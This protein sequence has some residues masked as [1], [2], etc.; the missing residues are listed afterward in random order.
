MKSRLFAVLTIA[1]ICSGNVWAA[2]ASDAKN[3]AARP[4]VAGLSQ[5]IDRAI[6]KTLQADKITASAKADDA[7]F[8]RRAS[9]DITGV[10]PSA[11]KAAVFLDST[12]PDK[13]AKL[14]DE[15]LA[16]P[17][18]GRHMADIW[19]GLLVQ[20]DS[21]NRRVTFD[22]LHTW[23][24]KGFN[25]NRSWDKF[26][27]EL[28]TAS[29]PQSENGAVTF[30]LANPTPDKVTDQVTR[31]FLGVQ[32]QCAQCHNHPFTSWKREE[33]WGMAAFFFKVKA[34]RANQKNANALAVME[35]GTTGKGKQAKLPDSAR[36][37][38]AKFLQGEQPKMDAA[39]PNRPVLAKWMTTPENPFFAPA[40][41]NRMWAHFFGRG[42]VNPVDDMHEGNTASHPELLKEMAQN[43]AGSG[44]D[45]K[46]LIR[47][48]CN[49][50]AYQRTSKPTDANKDDTK[51]S[52][53]SLKPMSPEQLYDSLAA[54]L[55]TAGEP[56]GGGKQPQAAGR[57]PQ[58][59]ARTQFAN[60][61]RTDESAIAP[62]YNSGIP[63][64]L[65]LMNAPQLNR[66]G[67]LL[68]AVKSATPEQTVERLYL[69]T[70]SRRPA[71]QESERMLAYVQKHKGEERKAYTDILWALLNSS[72]FVLNH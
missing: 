24:E 57:R 68:D 7:E 46:H 13:R 35:S 21:N 28:V 50:Q 32:L 6:D 22:S 27:T 66:G 62:D 10:I 69:G 9:L 33:Y 59:N 44:F 52:H 56:K 20:A 45:V 14:I 64:A 72:E 4:N 63:Q 61:F 71:A 25:E 19:Q 30:F 55:G 34:D 54:V 39:E 12:D 65:R 29:G 67:A 47:G 49:S 11:E 36:V 38:P 40:M 31:L 1:S 70:L 5:A 15:L 8:L 60:F 43:F 48:I 17:A 16:S 37:V 2:E 51:F 53:M 26:V 41:A 18:Y 23:L 3:E 42:F 58:G